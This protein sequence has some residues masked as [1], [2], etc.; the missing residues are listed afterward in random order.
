MAPNTMLMSPAAK[1]RPNETRSA[2]SVR[3]AVTMAMNRS[4]VSSLVL[5]NSA[6]S[7]SRTMSP[8]QVRV[9]PSVRPKPGMTLGCRKVRRDGEALMEGL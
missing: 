3:V 6:D 1:A 2:C 5:M 7:G 9:R 4:K 8:S